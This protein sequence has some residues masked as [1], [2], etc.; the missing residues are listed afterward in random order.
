MQIIM[1]IFCFANTAHGQSQEKLKFGNN[2][3]FDIISTDTRMMQRVWIKEGTSDTQ[4]SLLLPKLHQLP[5]PRKVWKQMTSKKVNQH[6]NIPLKTDLDTSSYTEKYSASDMTY[7]SNSTSIDAEAKSPIILG[8]KL[9]PNLT[10]F[11]SSDVN[12]ISKSFP[13]YIINDS[14]DAILVGLG[15]TDENVKEYKYHVVK[16]DSVEIIPWSPIP[17]IEQKYGATRPYAFLG[18]FN[19]PGNQLLVEVVNRKDYSIRDGVI[20]DWRINYKPIV[21]QIIINTPRNYFNINC[22]KLN[23]NYATKFDRLTGI[24]LDLKFPMDSINNFGIS[25]KSHPTIAYAIYLKKEINGKVD[26]DEIDYYI[27]EDHYDFGNQH[28]KTP[29]KYELMIQRTQSLN[30]FGDKNILRIPFEVLAPRPLEKKFSAKQ[31]I[32]YGIGI[33]LI[34]STIFITYYL[35]NKRKLRKSARQKEKTE[36]QLKSIRSQLNPH[37]MFNAL[38]SIQ[39]L[40]NKSDVEA[41]NHYLAKFASLTRKVLNTGEHDLI[42]LADEITLLDDYLQME[43]LRFGFT[44]T[45]KADE[46]LN[47]ANIEIPAMLLQPFVENAVKHGIAMMRD[48][49]Q[50]EIGFTQH[51]KN[52]VLSVSDNGKG[53]QEKIHEPGNPG[54]GLKLSRERIALLNKTYTNQCIS[55]DI[56]PETTGT[57]VK[58]TLGDWL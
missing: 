8:V 2:F 49:G 36:L 43:Q 6:A 15:I 20:F 19:A 44:Y 38:N 30:Y 25:F 7:Y 51:A 46:S 37:F 3:Y 21:N 5:Y 31:I 1:S 4:I 29:G 26:T 24:P 32:P 41:A 12:S 39:N 23:R 11:F 47:K 28:F 57:K 17:K 18:K 48:K 16:N 55:M 13:C 35:N 33:L 45:I 54:L 42:S 50:I 58:I 14:S 34:L 53:F 22:K 10:D 56:V 9:N 27:L 40:M 52:L